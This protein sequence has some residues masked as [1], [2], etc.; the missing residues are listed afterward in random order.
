MAETT[1]G[2]EAKNELSK[3]TYIIFLLT[4]HITPLVVN[5]RPFTAAHRLVVV[6]V[7][8]RILFV[9]TGAIRVHGTGLGRREWLG[10]RH[11]RASR[12]ESCTSLSLGEL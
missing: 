10:V 7:I 5:M 2:G 11:V 12:G 9:M 4:T 6:L 3:R 1:L 8:A